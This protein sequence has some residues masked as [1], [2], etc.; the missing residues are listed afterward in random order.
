MIHHD[1]KYPAEYSTAENCMEMQSLQL[2]AFMMTVCNVL[3]VVQDWFTDINFLRFLLTAEMLKPSTPNSHDGPSV[4]ET[5]SDYYPQLV[6]IQNK[7]TRDDFS[8][9]T[10]RAMQTTL[11]KVFSNSKLKYTGSVTLANGDLLPGLNPRTVPSNINLYLLPYMDN[12]KTEGD[13]ILT[14]LPEYRGYPSFSRLLQSLRN[15][16]FASQRCLLTHTILSEKNWFHYAARTWDAVKKSPLMGPPEWGR[17]R[18]TLFSRTSNPFFPSI[19]VRVV[20]FG[21]VHLSPERTYSSKVT[22]PTPLLRIVS[23]IDLSAMS[24]QWQPKSDLPEVRHSVFCFFFLLFLPSLFL[25]MSLPDKYCL[26]ARVLSGLTRSRLDKTNATFSPL[27]DSHGNSHGYSGVP[28]PT[29]RPGQFS[30][31]SSRIFSRSAFSA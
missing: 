7:A 20:P 9:E 23:F 22:A 21:V 27:S 14:F 2:A 28:P 26:K 1:K 5:S 13:S 8:V 17:A 19:G 4:Q 31:L 30:L 12:Q 18:I 29:A 6:F 25:L 3:L 24:K 11:S 16:V 10:F 15:Q